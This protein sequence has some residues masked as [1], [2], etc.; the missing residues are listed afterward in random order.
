MNPGCDAMLDTRDAIVS[1]AEAMGALPKDIK[2]RVHTEY[3]ESGHRPGE[4][5]RLGELIGA[6]ADHQH[7]FPVRGRTAPSPPLFFVGEPS[8]INRS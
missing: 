7:M 3:T 1:I 5:A 8:K 2:F 6:S 4:I